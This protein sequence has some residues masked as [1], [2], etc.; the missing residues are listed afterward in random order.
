MAVASKC[1][2]R[3]NERKCYTRKNK[4]SYQVWIKL[5]QGKCM[6][7]YEFKTHFCMKNFGTCLHEFILKPVKNAYRYYIVFIPLLQFLDWFLQQNE[8]STHIEVMETAEFKKCLRKFYISAHY[9][10]EFVRNVTLACVIIEKIEYL[11][12][13]LLFRIL[14]CVYILKQLV[15]SVSVIIGEYLPCRSRTRGSVNIHR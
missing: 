3:K 4:E 9:V 14:P 5:F 1:F 12:F 6:I 2:V 7:K 10:N 11:F 15:S 8:F 13:I